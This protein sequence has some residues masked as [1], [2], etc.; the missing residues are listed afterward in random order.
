MP[1][2]D[3]LDGQ[4]QIT[5]PAGKDLKL[6]LSAGGRFVIAGGEDSSQWIPPTAT[7]PITG[8]WTEVAGQVAGTICKH[9]GAAA[10]TATVHI[11]ILVRSS[12]D[13]NKGS[14]LKTI[15]VDYEVLVAACTSV[16]AVLQKI[17]RGVDTAVAV[18]SQ[19]AIT[20]DLVAATTA[21]SVEQHKMIVTLTTPAWIG[22]N[23][24]Y[25]LQMVFVAATTTQ[26]DVLGAV[27]NYT[28]RF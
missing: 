18:V 20:Q 11:P 22:N 21:A 25:I 24:Y 4:Y 23:E 12:S 13:A 3:I 1:E 27:A 10:E 15:E 7:L 2:I 5:P 14:L 6:T 8:T 26:L 28:N 9:K 17:V 16:T 19:P